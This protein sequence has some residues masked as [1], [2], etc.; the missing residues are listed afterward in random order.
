M[1]NEKY[2]VSPDKLYWHCDESR[3]DFKTTKDLK[4]LKG[5]IGQ[6]RALKSLDFGLGIIN[7]GYNIYVL[8]DSGTGKESVV[9]DL[10]AE[11]AQKEPSPRDLCYVFNFHDS[12]RPA[13]ITLPSGIGAIFKD[14]M[15]G[16]VE[17]LLKDIPHVFESKDYENHR[18]E[19]L[20]GQ[21][22]RTKNIFDRVE[23][24]CNKDG[25]KL[26][27]SVSG[28]TI[29]AVDVTGKTLRDEDFK[30][31][32]TSEKDK[33]EAKLKV[34]QTVLSDAV[35]EVR[36]VEKSSHDR[37]DKLD[38]EVVHYVVDPQMSELFDKYSDYDEVV[39]Y[40]KDVKD[41]IYYNIED[42]RAKE[43][44]GLQIPGL[45]FSKDEP[46][47]TR[48][49]VNL[50]VNNKDIKGAPVVFEKN[51]TYYNLFGRLE[52]KMQYGVATTDFTM[53]K[54]GS[55]HRANGGYLVLN[56]IDV[57]RNIFVYDGLKRM[58]KNKE[59][60]FEDVWEQYRLVSSSTIKPQ[61][62]KTDIKIVLIGEP[63]IYYLLYNLDREYRELFKVKVDFDNMIEKNETNIKGIAEFV[64]SRCEEHKLLPFNKSGVAKVVEYGVREATHK[65]KIS[66]RFGEMD[67]VLVE[68]SHYAAMDDKKSVSREY[69]EKAIEEKKY[70]H[71][72]IEDK[73][74]EYIIE[75][76][77]MVDVDGAVVGQVNGLAVIDMGDYDFGKPSR[78]T[79]K[80][81]MGDK[82]VVNIEREAKMSGR[83]YNKSHLILTSFLGNR[84][85]KDF[86]MTL[87]AFLCFE[88]LYEGIEGDSA[89]CAE[90]YALISSLSNV[91]LKQ[92]IAATGSMNQQGEVQP[93]GGVNVKIEGFYRVCKEKGFTGDQ[94]VII[95]DRNVKNLMLNREVRES[96]EK[97]EFTIYAIRH[98]DEGLS[99]LT[100]MEAGTP[101]DHGLFADGTVNDLA[102]KKLK[103]LARHIKDFAKG[104]LKNKK[105]PSSSDNGNN[106]DDD[107][108]EDNDDKGGEKL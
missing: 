101:D 59:L 30:K 16:L 29:I 68:A 6:E 15:Y 53:L 57:L 92:N 82:G 94:G 100:G 56:A 28:L 58:I 11:K 19:I 48:Y 70:R 108:D 85:A 49:E 99:I 80:T 47:F 18:D 1:N 103:E 54:S 67:T 24:K 12:D 14:D 32:S 36:A 106:N 93:I 102:Y 21:Q 40:L 44:G 52:Y 78:V 45:K 81:Y 69:I 88:Q 79:A 61:P 35:R 5:I 76:T 65:K 90:V 31:F 38:R 87:N 46:V 83:I 7:N 17:T 33:M 73:L 55:I 42:F 26:K 89:T 50:L 84:Y 22:E 27:R 105:L 86:P 13:A 20:D 51:P 71:S 91:P 74:R 77:I 104:P 72:K 107:K 43:D 60:G 10:L 9:R 41:D 98:V 66:S 75:D 8:G 23:K 97:G 39:A 25:F 64:A 34:L 96:V 62:V 63:Y 2:I 3:F 37:L 95:P 4:P